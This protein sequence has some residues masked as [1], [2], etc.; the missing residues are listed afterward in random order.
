M[1]VAV[2]VAMSIPVLDSPDMLSKFNFVDLSSPPTRPSTVDSSSLKQP[3]ETVEHGQ[4]SSQIRKSETLEQPGSKRP[5]VS[6]TPVRRAC[7]SPNQAGCQSLTETSPP[8]SICDGAGSPPRSS[9]EPFG[10]VKQVQA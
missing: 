3:L 9:P 2:N 7:Y 1:S 6:P 10:D 8:G 5:C 4:S